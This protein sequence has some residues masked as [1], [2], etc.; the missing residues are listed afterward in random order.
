MPDGEGSES[1]QAGEHIPAGR[2]MHPSAAGTEAP[3]L[4]TLPDLS[5]SVSSS[6]AFIVS[7]NKLVIVSDC[8][9]EFCEPL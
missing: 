1:F 6:V 8:F 4:G 5:L 7:F 3:A 9:P 2:V